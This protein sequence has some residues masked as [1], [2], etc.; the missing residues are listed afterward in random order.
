[1]FLAMLAAA[2]LATEVT[3]APAP[4]PGAPAAAPVAGAMTYAPPKAADQKDDQLV[5]KTTAVLGSRLPVRRCATVGDVK[6]RA[7]QD[8]ETIRHA[9][10]NLQWR[11]N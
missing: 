7:Q 9:Q 5:C 1:M 2:A 6:D 4:A 10:E 3:A 8:R 11:S